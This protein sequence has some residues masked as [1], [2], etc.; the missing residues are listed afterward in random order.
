VA[1]AVAEIETVSNRLSE[2]SRIALEAS[3]QQAEGSESIHRAMREIA[4]IAQ[5]TAIGM[6]QSA[7]T[8]TQLALSAR[9][10]RTSLAS[11][12]L[13]EETNGVNPFATTL[14][15]LN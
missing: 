2:L 6:R 7:S 8:V 11:F 3:H 4:S 1:S 13:P 5:Q 14:P 15:S 10:L 9:E 12:K